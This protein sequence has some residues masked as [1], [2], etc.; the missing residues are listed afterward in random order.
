MKT[1]SKCHE[2]KNESEFYFRSIDQKYASDCKTC[3]SIQRK[4]QY[5]ENPDKFRARGREYNRK[6]SAAISIR[7]KKYYQEHAKEICERVNKYRKAHPETIK[8]IKREYYLANKDKWNS[9]HNN[10][11]INNPEKEAARHKKWAQ[12][13]PEKKAA[14]SHRHEA[15]KRGAN[16]VDFSSRDWEELLML[17][18]HHC[19]YCGKKETKDDILTQDHVIPVSHGGNHTKD[20]IVPACHSCNCSKHNKPLLVWMYSRIPL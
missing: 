3:R 19:I 15:L 5:L 16:I 12:D 8:F 9:K 1:C 11:A 6:N 20:N 4:E 13:N 14:K 17:Y 7:R 18:D 10:W 2:S